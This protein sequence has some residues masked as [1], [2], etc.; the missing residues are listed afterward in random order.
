[1]IS[2][3]YIARHGET[4]EN[5]QGIV[6]GHSYGMLS[7]RGLRQAVL[8]AAR[9]STIPLDAIWSSDLDRARITAETIAKSHS[10]EVRIDRRLREKS[11]G[12]YEGRPSSDY[13][14]DRA[15]QNGN[16]LTFRVSGGET[17]PELFERCDQFL[18]ELFDTETGETVLIV[19]HGGTNR[20]LLRS[21]LK[22]T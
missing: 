15:A 16:P 22:L 20:G 12:I 5:A 4:N 9:F 7:E 6:Q 8:I 11:F 1:M 10:V 19:A 17:F 21:L 13:I 2:T 14:R 3:L 18:R